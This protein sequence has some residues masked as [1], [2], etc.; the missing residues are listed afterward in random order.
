MKAEPQKAA[1]AEQVKS[2]L[3]RATQLLR[4]GWC[5][6]VGAR[7]AGGEQ[8]DCLSKSAVQWCAVG[9]VEK[10]SHM[11]FGE[12]ESLRARLRTAAVNKLAQAV[13]DADKPEDLPKWDCVVSEYQDKHGRRLDEVLALFAAAGRDPNG[14]RRG[15]RIGTRDAP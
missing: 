8:I 7:D 1:T 3:E 13:P 5:Q 12:D 10:A 11:L 15:Q 6:R 14:D 9:A 2:V 4:K